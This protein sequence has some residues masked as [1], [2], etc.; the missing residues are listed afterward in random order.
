[1]GKKS[2]LKQ[3]YDETNGLA[4]EQASDAVISSLNFPSSLLL[5][6]SK[7][8]KLPHQQP[9]ILVPDKIWVL[10]NF[11]TPEECEL[12]IQYFENEMKT[13]YI[14]QRGTR[15]LAS[16]ECYRCHKNDSVMSRRIYNR[17]QSTT[18]LFHLLP[19]HNKNQ[20]SGAA[21]KTTMKP[22]MCNPNI[23]IYKYT[24]GMSFGQHV[25]E[26]VVVKNLGTTKLTILIYLS[27]CVGGATRFEKN[28]AS[29][30][31]VQGSILLHIHGNDCLL[32]E[33]DPVT[34]GIKYVLRTDL[35]YSEM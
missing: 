4:K 22:C 35:V 15:Y 8:T 17:L 28:L 34:S 14:Q 18:Q 27:T 5:Q 19:P 1:M 29:F 9:I 33:A 26:S 6:D 13:E 25:D 32:H 21:N 30:E 10:S 20:S 12:W 16:R 31:P 23:R 11:F 2:K 3:Y 7:N 24:K